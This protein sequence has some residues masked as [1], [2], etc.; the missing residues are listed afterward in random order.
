M[1]SVH[2]ACELFFLLA[3]ASPAPSQS[4]AQDEPP[5]VVPKLWDA[6]GL[7]GWATPLAGLGVPPTLMSEEE[8]YALPVDDLRSYPVYHPR[9]EPPGYRE[10]LIARGPQPLIE[11]EKLKTRAD[12]IAAGRIVFE[13]IETPSSR[14]DDPRVIAHFTDADAIDRY[15]DASHDVISADGVILDYRWVVERDGK[16]KLSL[17]SCFGCHSRLMP[18]GSVLYGAPCNYDLSDAPAVQVMLDKIAP[19]LPGLS[20]G[21]MF[22]ASFGV[23]WRKDDVHARFKGMSDEELGQVLGQDSG[24]PP[25]TMFSRFNGSPF[26]KTRMADLRGV[27][28]RKYLDATGTHVHRG[29]ED[30]ARYG[31]L[32]E[33]APEVGFGQHRMLPESARKEMVRPPDAAMYALGLYVE[34][35]EPAPSPHP[36]GELAKR[37]QEVFDEEGCAKCHTPPIYTNN[38]LVAVPG[39]EPPRDDPR[40]AALDISNRRV[41]T[42]P[43]MALGTR[44]GTGYYKVPSLRGLWYRGLYG[45]SG[46]VTSLEEWFDPRR[47]RSDFVPS[48]WKGPGVKALAIPG[49][50]FGFDLSEQ[51]KRALIAFLLTL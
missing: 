12:W 15:R 31:I 39:F 20:A 43:G 16:L 38:K 49:H 46:F 21:E 32:V 3:L 27:H 41:G 47:Q 18:D 6:A 24:E 44:K 29:P 1:R 50:D 19:T 25:G 48:G 37:G 7:E 33:F 34:S 17:S 30:I 22:Y 26:F 42:D 14:S 51:D 4:V 23:P 8:Y 40:S 45:H 2:S 10:G 36:F 28:D 35:L 13:S 9:F 5:I 11:P